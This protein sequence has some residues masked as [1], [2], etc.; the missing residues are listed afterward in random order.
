MIQVT[1]LGTAA[2]MPLPG[3][4]LSAAAAFCQGRGIL[5]DCGEG[6]Q[7]AARAAR[8]SLL[9]LD[10][11]ALSHYH[12]D[13]IFGLP[14]LLQTMACLNRTEPVYICGPAG[15][16]RALDPILRLSGPLPFRVRPLRLPEAGLRLGRA[17]P[18]WPERAE[19]RPVSTVHRTP[20]QGYRLSLSRAGKFDPRRAAALG[21]PVSLWGRLQRGELLRYE[22]REICPEQ[23]LGPPRRGLSLVFTGDTAPCPAVEEAAR[24]ADLLIHDATYALDEQEPLAAEYGH[25]TFTQAAALASRSGARRLW[26]THFSQTIRRPEE[27]LDLARAR[28]PAAQC[29]EDGMSLL[30]RFED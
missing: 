10:I 29:G 22:G 21:L 24:G 28:F 23:V 8:V 19:L 11:L 14:G 7:A 16:D 12:G 6:T 2:T 27:H 9:K 13:H 25:S 30:L 17:L 4:A 3:R 18:G 1:L 26:L 15:L 5:F 20:S